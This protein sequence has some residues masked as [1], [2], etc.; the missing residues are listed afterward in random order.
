MEAILFNCQPNAQAPDWSQFEAIQIGGCINDAE[1]GA[2]DTHIIGGIERDQAEFFCVYGHLKTGG[3]EAITDV[4][5]YAGAE[6]IASLFALQT[7]FAI[8]VHC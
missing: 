8:H 6:N 7:G 1:E 5:T 3:V 2:E 4:P